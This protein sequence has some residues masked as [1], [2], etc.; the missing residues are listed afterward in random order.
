MNDEP[1]TVTADWAVKDRTAALTEVALERRADDAQRAADRA[2]G[3]AVAIG[4]MVVDR[5]AGELHVGGPGEHGTAAAVGREP[6]GQHQVG[7]R[8]AP[9]ARLEQP[10]RP[11][12]RRRR[13]PRRVPTM[14][15]LPGGTASVSATVKVP[16]GSSMRAGCP[17]GWAAAA[18]KAAGSVHAPAASH[19]P[20]TMAVSSTT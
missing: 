1:V 5:H 2:D 4:A 8:E 14:V 11:G 18:A 9:A 17:A 20:P 6:V 15:T 3:A 7:E 13:S 16:A 19:D 10:G 12:R